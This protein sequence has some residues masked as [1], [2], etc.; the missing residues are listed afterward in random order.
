M[1]GRARKPI[2][3]KPKREEY[4]SRQLTEDEEFTYQ[5]GPF[6]HTVKGVAGEWAIFLNDNFVQC[7][8]DEDY[9]LVYEDDPSRGIRVN[10][11]V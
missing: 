7:I 3:P 11:T 2:K 6:E 9:G 8:S 5:A 4:E 1:P 10:R